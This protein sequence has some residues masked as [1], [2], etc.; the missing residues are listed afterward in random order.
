MSGFQNEKAGWL[1]AG[2]RAWMVA[3][4]EKDYFGEERRPRFDGTSVER[5]ASNGM[6]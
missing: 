5:M 3:L 1:V 4:Q 6:R 2:R